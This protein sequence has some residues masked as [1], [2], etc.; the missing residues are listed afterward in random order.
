MPDVPTVVEAGYPDSVSSSWQGLFAVAGTPQPIVARL[1]DAVVKALADPTV[2]AHM[3]TA[4]ML[5]SPSKSPEEFKAYITAETA[6]WDQVV[7]EI[8]AKPE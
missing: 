4:G 5:P 8:G 2:R 6:K 1:H 3:A 7:K